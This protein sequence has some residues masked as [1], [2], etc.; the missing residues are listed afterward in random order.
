M[1][2]KHLCVLIHLRVVFEACTV[3]HARVLWCFLL[4]IPGRCSLVDCLCCFCFLFVFV[5]LSCLFLAA[6]WSPA[7]K[8]LTSLCVVCS[9]V[10][11]TFPY[12]SLSTSG[13]RERFAPLNRDY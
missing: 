7:E 6:L 13:L 1:Q 9:C 11:L 12:T 3:R 10:C 8:G 5:V 4:T 2:T